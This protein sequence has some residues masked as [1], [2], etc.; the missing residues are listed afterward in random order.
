MHSEASDGCKEVGAKVV[1]RAGRKYI[2][3][4][5]A[6][7]PALCYHIVF[8][9]APVGYTRDVRSNTSTWEGGSPGVAK[10]FPL[11][12]HLLVQLENHKVIRAFGFREK[13]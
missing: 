4:G 11:T 5:S 13:F 6:F 7:P 9:W 3:T 1:C 10:P 8:T 12:Y 2:H